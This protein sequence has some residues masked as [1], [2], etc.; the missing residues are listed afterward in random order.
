[1]LYSAFPH[2]TEKF[3]SFSSRFGGEGNP[4][5]VIRINVPSVGGSA[6]S[7]YR[8]ELLP[9]TKTAISHQ[10][11]TQDPLLSSLARGVGPVHLFNRLSACFVAAVQLSFIPH[12]PQTNHHPRFLFSTLSL[13]FSFTVN[14]QPIHTV[15]HTRLTCLIPS[16]DTRSAGLSIVLETEAAPSGGSILDVNCAG[17]NIFA[18]TACI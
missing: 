6:M 9:K 1:M 13:L 8:V 11:E 17:T 10:F 15:H 12:H 16:R 14:P 4:W 18:K 5:R 2:F 7:K 3:S